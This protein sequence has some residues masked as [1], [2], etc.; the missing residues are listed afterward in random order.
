MQYERLAD[1]FELH[2]KDYDIILIQE[3]FGLMFSDLK[4]LTVTYA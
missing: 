4:E 1:M 3:A 2:F